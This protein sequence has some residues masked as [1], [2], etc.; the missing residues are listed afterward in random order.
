MLHS[1]GFRQ[2]VDGRQRAPSAQHRK[3]QKK[4]KTA[5]GKIQQTIYSL[6]IM[7]K[8]IKNSMSTISCNSGDPSL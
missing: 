5:Q 2:T 4:K 8:N 1:C 3:N 6:Q 7:E